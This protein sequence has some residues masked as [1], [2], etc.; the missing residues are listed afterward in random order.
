VLDRGIIGNVVTHPA[1]LAALAVTA[2]L[3]WPLGRLLR[4][5]ALGIVFVAVL[6]AVLAATMTTLTPP[7]RMTGAVHAYVLGFAHFPP[8][9]E[10]A[11][12]LANVGLYLPL[13]LVATL[14]WRR[15]V[16][17]T[18]GGAVLSFLIEAWQAHIGRGGDPVDVLHNAAGTL[19]GAALGYAVVRLRGAWRGPVT[20][21]A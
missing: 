15:P 13:G 7:D 4:R 19:L 20:P 9:T 3:A 12:R 8:F 1:V 6:G 16:P 11:E 5:G 17:V 2:V 10:N 18:V 21:P 14:M